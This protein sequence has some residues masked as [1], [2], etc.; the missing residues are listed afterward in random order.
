[1]TEHISDI[2]ASNGMAWS[3]DWSKMYY[4][5]TLAQKIIPLTMMNL[6]VPSLTRQWLWTM[7]KMMLLVYQTACVLMLREC[8][9]LLD[10][11]EQQ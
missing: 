7:L 5:D 4:I 3:P 9:G 11:L 8:C 6:L 2:S 1:M 10:A